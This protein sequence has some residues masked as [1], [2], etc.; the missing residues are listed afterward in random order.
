MNI[1]II[2][3]IFE[4]E[5]CPVCSKPD[6]KEYKI[7][8]DEAEKLYSGLKSMLN[9]EQLTKVNAYVNT[10]IKACEC[11]RQHSYVEGFSMAY[12]VSVQ[13]LHHC[14]CR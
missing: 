13:A 7:A 11:E 4:A 6:S 12:C 5:P 3:Q 2:E 8:K 14:L 9:E 10:L 1:G